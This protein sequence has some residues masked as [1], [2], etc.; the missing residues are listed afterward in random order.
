MRTRPEF[1]DTLRRDFERLEGHTFSLMWY[2]V[3][4]IDD[5]GGVTEDSQWRWSKYPDRSLRAR[6]SALALRGAVGLGYSSEDRWYDRLRE[7]WFVR[8]AFSGEGQAIGPDGEVVTWKF[9]PINDV[10]KES[11]TLCHELESV[12]ANGEPPES[13]ARMM[14]AMV[15]SGPDPADTEPQMNSDTPAAKET[16]RRRAFLAPFL[17][18]QTLSAIALE[19]GVL[20]S[21]L[22]RWS[23]GKCRLRSDNLAK[24]ADYL[25]VPVSDIPNSRA[26]KQT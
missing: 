5:I 11:V 9:G 1:W 8:F 24:V 7:S 18:R 10:V 26:H 23:T 14:S 3:P 12:T 17:E 16:D 25:R 4:P 13:F 22:H 21:S 15:V 2:S 19:S 6:V 20:H